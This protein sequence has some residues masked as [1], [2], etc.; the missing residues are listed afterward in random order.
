MDQ[1]TNP[2]ADGG[3]RTPS[4]EWPDHSIG[5]MNNTSGGGLVGRVIIGASLGSSWGL[6]GAAGGAV[7]GAVL[8]DVFEQ[9]ANKR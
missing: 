4:E 6:G 2:R 7:F 8:G 9:T 1:T 5:F 3:T